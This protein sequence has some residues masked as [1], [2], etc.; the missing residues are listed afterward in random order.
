MTKDEEIKRQNEKIEFLA[1]TNML[2]SDWEHRNNQ[3]TSDL[4]HKG[5]EEAKIN[6]ELRAE[7]KRLKTQ[8]P[9]TNEETVTYV[10]D[11]LEGKKF[12]K[13]KHMIDYL[14]GGQ[15]YYYPFAGDEPA[16]KDTKVLL[17]TRGGM[18]I[19]GFWDDS[20]CMGWL[21]LPKR[22]KEKENAV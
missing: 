21:P 9:D 19:T 17:L 6:S 20:W 10:A 1:R 11:V 5:I 15:E 12:N 16:P 13:R 2:Y 18:C 14:A 3:V 4:I 7:I 22:N 8:E